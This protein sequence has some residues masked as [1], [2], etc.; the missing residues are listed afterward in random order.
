[1]ERE[2]YERLRQHVNHLGHGFS[3][4]TTG[5]ELRLLQKLFTEEH[6]KIYLH[7]SAD[8]ETPEQIAQREG[9]DPRRLAEVLNGMAEAGLVFPKRVGE[10]RYYAAAPAFHGFGEHQVLRMDADLAQRLEDYN[11]SEKIPEAPPPSRKAVTTLPLRT[12]PVNATI[13]ISRPIAPYEDVKEIIRKQD[14][15]AVAKCYCF[16]QQEALGKHSNQPQEVCLFLGFYADYY[17]D[18]G[19]G[20]RINQDEALEILRIAEEAGLVHQIPN[21]TDPGAICNCGPDCCGQLNALKNLP[22]PAAYVMSDHFAEAKPDLCNSCEFCVTRCPMI[23][24][25]MSKDSIAEIS[26]ERCIG[27]GLCVSTCPTDAV[28]L[29]NK[30]GPELQEQPGFTTQFMRSSQDIESTIR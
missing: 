20:R 13:S 26:R 21:T 9:L 6:A 30:S 4:T 27:C 24:I 23:A 12:I 25:T 8:L 29:A 11:W 17:V 16:A 22:N 18:L 1:M 3:A 28:V 2:I 19:M 10:Q 15:L 14:R 5:A 7:L